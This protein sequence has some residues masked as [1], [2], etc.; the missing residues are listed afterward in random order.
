MKKLPLLL[1]IL[2]IISCVHRE[3]HQPVAE[4]EKKVD[5]LSL[6]SQMITAIPLETNS[7]C[8]LA[9]INQVKTASSNIFILSNNEI[10]RFNQSGIFLNKIFTDNHARVARYVINPDN[11]HIIILDSLSRLHYFSYNGT[12]LFT[13]EAENAISGQTIL[14]MAYHDHFLWV[15]T[16]KIAE[17]QV[18]EKWIHQMNLAFE[19]LESSKLSTAKLDR[20]YLDG[21]LSSAV[22]VADNKVYVYAAFS[23]KETILQDTLYLVSSG[24]F[25]KDKLCRNKN[26]VDFPAY[27]IPVILGKRYLM[28]SYQANISESANYF[29]CY[30]TKTSQSFRMNGFNDDFFHTGIVKDLQPFSSNGQ[31]YYFCKSGKDI[32]ASFPDRDENSNPVL[33]VVRLHG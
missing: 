15:V 20:F 32:A 30:D 4:E 12:L 5:A 18:I 23:S 25:N 26:G 14:D 29:F 33:F 22:Y 1:L 9:I 17:D 21:N 16:N 24:Q 13:K 11:E 8:K 2:A 27:S 3:K 19:P 6:I 7:Q 10:F 31:D 28:A